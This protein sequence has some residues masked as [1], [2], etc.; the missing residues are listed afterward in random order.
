MLG[1]ALGLLG[2][3]HGDG[4]GSCAL[5]ITLQ[6]INTGAEATEGRRDETGDNGQ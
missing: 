3:R 1:N 5:Q 4:S 6:V 2:M